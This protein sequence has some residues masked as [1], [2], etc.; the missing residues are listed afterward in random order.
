MSHQQN[1]QLIAALNNCVAE[2][3]HCTT[4]C[5]GEQDVKMLAKCIGLDIDCADICTLVAALTARGSEHAK[6]LLK[7]CAEVCNACAE[8]CEK[9]AKMG[10]EHCRTCAEACRA[11]AAAC[12][13][14]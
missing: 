3:N 11:C 4:A 2:C 9:H 14:G 1:H 6:H 13:A 8:E 10:M 12:S 7:E 5:L